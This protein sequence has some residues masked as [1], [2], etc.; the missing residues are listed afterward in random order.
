MTRDLPLHRYRNIGIMAHIDAGKTTVSERILLFTGRIHRAGEVHDGNTA[1]DWTEAEKKRGITITSAATTAYWSPLTG[2]ARGGKHRVNLIDTPGHVDF[3]IEV[4]RSLRVLDGAV[5]VFDAGN[6]VEP[7]SEAVWRQADHYGVARIAFINKMDKVGADF[8]MC[9]DSMRERL[10]AP[11]VAVQLPIGESDRFEGVIDLVR[12]C[13][14]FFDDASGRTFRTA[15]IPGGLRAAAEAARRRLIEVC[16]DFDDDVLAKVVD[17]RFEAV[18]ESEIERALRRATLAR[19]AV[20]VL[21]GS[22]LRNKG[23]QMLLDAVVAYLPSPAD[24]P[25]AVGHVPATGAEVTFAADDAAPF[26]ALAFKLMADKNAGTIAFLRVY[27]G[28]VDSGATVHVGRTGRRE[29]L[30]RLLLMHANTQ[31]GI[32]GAAT[33]MIIGAIGLKDVRTGD[34]LTSLDTDAVLESMVFPEPVVEL[35]IH[36]ATAADKDRLPGALR[37]LALEDPSLRVSTDEESGETRLRGM[38]ELHLEVVVDKLRTDHGVEARTGAPSVQYRETISRPAQ[39]TYRHV[40]QDGGPGQ[41]AVVTLRVAPLERGAGFRFVDETHGG[42]VPKEFVPSVR[43]GV[44][45]AMERGLIAGHPVVDVEAT[46]LDGAFHA[47]DSSGMAFE[48]AGSLAFQEAARL[49]GPHLLEPV[50]AVE[51]VTPAESLG[52][53]VGDLSGRRGHMLGLGERGNAR[54][55][56]AQ[57]PLSALFGYVPN[58]RGLSRGRATATL[59]FSHFAPVPPAIAKEVLGQ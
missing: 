41:F 45:G 51:T 1:L 43:K 6:G 35:A 28:Q 23:V 44:E 48:I 25:A 22:A 11:V 12:P 15:D 20:P 5:A 3:S 40:K 59:R 47:K 17:G 31:E 7:Q 13:A 32:D 37:K 56:Q 54:V 18:T 57:A 21:C 52:A 8:A 46:L 38:G 16:A 49:A 42:S 14:Y 2:E 58:L 53:V 55:V 4:E 10:D 50:M 33:G 9:L 24:L 29:R 27:S 26:S 30:G 36:P 19:K 39:A 34:T